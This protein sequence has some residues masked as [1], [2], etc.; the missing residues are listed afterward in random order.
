MKRMNIKSMKIEKCLE[1]L[2]KI[3]FLITCL[4]FYSNL[5][6][7]KPILS[8]FMW[9]SIGI[10][11]IVI[12]LRLIRIKSVI[13][14]KYL[15]LLILFAFSHLISSAVNIRYGYYENLKLLVWM[16]FQFGILYAYDDDRKKKDIRKEFFGLGNIYVII[17]F[18]LAI[19]S[20]GYLFEM[21][22]SYFIFLDD[23]LLQYGMSWGRLFGAYIDPNYGAVFAVLSCIISFYCIS[24]LR[25]WWA[26]IIYGINILSQ[27]IYVAL[28]DSRTGL[29]ALCFSIGFIILMLLLQKTTDKR[30]YIRWM[31]SIFGA[32]VISFVV[33]IAVIGIEKGYST[34]NDYMNSRQAVETEVE[35]V[36]EPVENPST[37]A[38]NSSNVEPQESVSE[39]TE[40][41]EE[42]R[43]QDL[44]KDI[45][46]RRFDLWKAGIEI[47]SKE[48]IIGVGFK[49]IVSYVQEEI[50][51]SYLITND[52][53]VFDN[54]H[55]AFFNILA[56]QGPFGAVIFVAI[57]L[58]FVVYV[59]RRILTVKKE[60][61]YIVVLLCACLGVGVCS[62]MF[63]TDVFYA[64]TPTAFFFWLCLGYLIQYLQQEE[65]VKN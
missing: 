38:S 57:V 7:G 33:L 60:E 64:I 14:S 6:F 18:V 8:Y 29:V 59:F 58:V 28:S 13:K 53:G 43:E 48:P 9:L 21:K 42:G 61:Y 3:L 17:T 11:G 30:N 63:V 44:K 46:N 52:H 1:I 55:N 40:V 16:V 39:N 50:P 23:Y 26:Y 54:M 15:W 36:A 31:K 24:Y 4:M 10:G 65:G 27:V 5:T 37:V 2:F 49:N 20:F 47:F 32:G 45:S 35:T 56:G 51:D 22:E 34:I 12:L 19:L 25:K 62:M 41:V